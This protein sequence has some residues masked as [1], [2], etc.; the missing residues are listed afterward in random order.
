MESL[1]MNGNKNVQAPR[2]DDTKQLPTE[3]TKNGIWS[4]QEVP[5]QKLQKE[6]SLI[7]QLTACKVFPLEEQTGEKKKKLQIKA[8]YTISDGVSQVKALVPDTH[9]IKFVSFF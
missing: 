2:S 4:L 7:V 8:K 5:A 1:N 6:Q 3:L 9:Y